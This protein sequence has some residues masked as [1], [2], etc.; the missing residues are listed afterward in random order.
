NDAAI[1]PSCSAFLHRPHDRPFLLV[2]SFNNPHN[3]CEHA[4]DQPLPDGEVAPPIANQLPDLP[5]NH[6]PPSDEC[7]AIDALRPNHTPGSPRHDWPAER[8]QTYRHTY[9][10]LCEKVDAQVGQ[11]LDALRDA[12][13]ADDTLVV[14]L[15]DHG[16]MQGAHGLNQ[17]SWFYDE[18]VRIPFI[19]QPPGG[20]HARVDTSLVSPG[21]DLLPTLLDYAHHARHDPSHEGK[22]LRACIDEGD[23]VA[24]HAV[25]SEVIVDRSELAGRMVVT[26]R[27]KYSVFD[28]GTPREMFVDLARDPGELTNLAPDPNHADTLQSH[29]TLLNDWAARTA[30]DFAKS[31]PFT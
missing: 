6:A 7:S 25:F 28:D 12:G 29:R 17:K 31:R 21:L 19:I 22:T 1:P 9:F 4:R 20:T 11:V 5:P 8:W 27:F 2:A 30:D 13:H 10:R 3:I 18:S 26:D 14:F 23:P 15:S 24:R 16:D